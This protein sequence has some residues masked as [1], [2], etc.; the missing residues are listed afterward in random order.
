[1][2]ERGLLLTAQLNFTTQTTPKRCQWPVWHR[3]NEK[4]EKRQNRRYTTYTRRCRY[5]PSEISGLGMHRRNDLSSLISSTTPE[6]CRNAPA[7]PS[8][9]A[10]PGTLSKTQ[11]G[12]QQEERESERYNPRIYIHQDTLASRSDYQVAASDTSSTTGRHI[13]SDPLFKRS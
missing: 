12:Y 1:M 5:S 2:S 10:E 7:A 3:Q 4:Y 8:A 13:P 6:N 11:T 9:V